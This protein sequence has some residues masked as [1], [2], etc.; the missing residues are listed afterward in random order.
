MSKGLSLSVDWI[1]G[2]AP[3]LITV[4]ARDLVAFERHYNC[5]FSAVSKN[6][7]MEQTFFLAHQAAR[8]MQKFPGEF[9]AFLDAVEMVGEPEEEEAADPTSPPPS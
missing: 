4:V 3:T 2:S 1:D 8:R 5:S 9:E 7:T 6:I